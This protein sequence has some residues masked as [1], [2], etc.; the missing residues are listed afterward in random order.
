[1]T[2]VLIL[3]YIQNL[4]LQLWFDINK[5]LFFHSFSPYDYILSVWSSFIYM[6]RNIITYPILFAINFNIYQMY[7]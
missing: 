4:C 5:M 2:H 6:I 1:M 3:H 7:L